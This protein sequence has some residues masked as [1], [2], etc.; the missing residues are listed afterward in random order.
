MNFE[1]I[2]QEI[3]GVYN[4][5]DKNL[6]LANGFTI[7]CAN[8]NGLSSKNIIDKVHKYFKNRKSTR[9]IKNVEE[10]IYEVENQVIKQIY[11]SL[12]IDK[13]EQLE[14]KDKII[15]FLDY[16][17]EYYTLNYDHILYK[18][19]LMLNDKY[20]PNYKSADGFKPNSGQLLWNENNLQNT[21]YLHGAF[22]LIKNGD[23]IKKV[24]SDRVNNLYRAINNEWEK[25]LKSHVII[26]SDYET[27]KLKI[28]N[29]EFSPYL[30][31]CFDSFKKINGVLVT[32]GVSFSESD[33]HIVEAIKNNNNLKKLY[34]G[35]HTNN[36]FKH[37]QEL[38]K[39]DE[40]DYEIEYYCSKD[41]FN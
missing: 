9:K 11:S 24:S 7:A 41:I 26:S 25:G 12:P 16:F 18:L 35:W 27:K 3:D 32:M 23:C 17:E 2:R 5:C 39:P 33:M 36:D 38:F 28:T 14:N 22:H 40:V 1:D 4:N 13:I 10:Y 37:F 20:L 19:L 6:L 21:Y 8:N 30:K 31:Y 34:L 15:D 29:G